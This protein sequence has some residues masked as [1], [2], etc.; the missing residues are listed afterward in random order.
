MSLRAQFDD[1]IRD[2]E[3]RWVNPSWWNVLIALPWALGAIFFIYHWNVDRAIATRQRTTEGVI[4][5]HDRANHD[6]H[7]YVFTVDGET[8]SGWGVP[9][10]EELELG[11]RVVVYYDPQDPK[12]NSL[13]DFEDL[14][15]R[16]FGSVALP[17]LGIGILVGYIGRQRRRH[18]MNSG[19]LSSTEP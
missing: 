13:T 5:A 3:R 12:K 2:I 8:F 7:E 16:E 9:Q 17:L 4:T 14:G 6:R 19:R 10:K 1:G 18:R 15:E 11:K